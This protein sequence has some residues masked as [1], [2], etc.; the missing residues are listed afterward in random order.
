[1]KRYQNMFRDNSWA[2]LSK[3][4]GNYDFLR[5]PPIPR[6]PWN[7]PGPKNITSHTFLLVFK[8]L[9]SLQC[10]VNNSTALH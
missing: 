3:K 8:I 9:K 2:V 4:K 5:I 1:M 7:R 10:I 6:I